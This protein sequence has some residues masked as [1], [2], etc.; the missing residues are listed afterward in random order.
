MINMEQYLINLKRLNRILNKNKEK[1]ITEILQFD[2][3]NINSN[4]SIYNV[5][6]KKPGIVLY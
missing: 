4:F 2:I 1:L 3:Y 5:Y 6:I